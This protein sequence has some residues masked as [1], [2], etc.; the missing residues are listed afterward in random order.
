[1]EPCFIETAVFTREVTRLGL[2][3][4]LVEL[5]ALLRHHPTAGVVV[6]GTGGVRKVRMGARERGRGKRGGARVHYLWL[7]APRVIYL[8]VVYAK[9]SASTLSAAGKRQARRI[10]EAIKAEWR[11]REGAP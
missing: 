9:D 3:P 7:P 2:E 5:Q 6:P 4:D 11:L 10:V 8:L 1:M